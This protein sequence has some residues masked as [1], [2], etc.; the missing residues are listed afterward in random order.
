MDILVDF[1][2]NLVI[3]S[4]CVCLIGLFTSLMVQSIKD[5]FRH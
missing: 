5:M 3:I 1:M 2:I 4:G